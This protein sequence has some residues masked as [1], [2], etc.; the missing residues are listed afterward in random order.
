MKDE[1]KPKNHP[2]LDSYTDEEVNE[3][4]EWIEDLTIKQAFF[5]KEHYELLLN[6]HARQAGSNYVQ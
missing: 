2:E 6:H 1:V 5:L 4:A 3:L